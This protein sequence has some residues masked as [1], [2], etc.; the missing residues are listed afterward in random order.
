[1]DNKPK[2]SL[3]GEEL[4]CRV[5]G[6]GD[7]ALTLSDYCWLH[8]QDKEEYKSRLLKVLNAEKSG[9]KFNL[10]KI[11][12]E[13][14]E[15]MNIDFSGANLTQSVIK[16]SNLFYNNFLKTDFLGSDLS[17]S[18]FTGSVL[19]G[20]DLTKCSLVGGRFWHSDF[21]DAILTEA[22]LTGADLWQSNLHNA[23]LWRT[24]LVG[25][26][27]ITRQNFS[28]KIA[29]FTSIERIDEKTHLVAEDAYRELKRYFITHGR[30]NDASWAA[31]K[32]KTMEKVRLKKSHNI[33]YLPVA[34]MGLLCGYGER[35]HRV[36]MSSAFIVLL[37]GIAFYALKAVRAPLN[38]NYIL[39][40]WD[41]IY[42]S[43][44]TFT[45]L[46]YGDIIP[47]VDFLYKM[48]AVSEAFIGAFMMG[49]FVFTLARKYS[50][51]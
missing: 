39:N 45:T 36:I 3:V 6:C 43:V 15:L 25:A 34:L 31:F 2:L 30:Y 24:D 47:K 37:Y 38:T 12:L 10:K 46:G 8:I 11:V 44:V 29:R 1:M 4:V 40:F 22:D 41:H 27:F 33:A 42:Y 32:E 28:R 26:K 9:Q 14:I 23:R 5:E 48:L 18:D 50:A 13:G 20:A 49:L 16:D 21:S 17:R 7:D 35:P 51:R 19:A